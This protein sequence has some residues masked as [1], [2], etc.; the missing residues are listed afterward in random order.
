ML[1]GG[2]ASGR[3]CD[4]Q[5]YSVS[6]LQKVSNGIIGFRGIFYTMRKFVNIDSTKKGDTCFFSSDLGLIWKFLTLRK[7]FI[8]NYNKTRKG[9]DCEEKFSTEF[10]T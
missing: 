4:Q 8:E 6:D 10:T 7:S 9:F 3:V 2:V 1:I 5:R